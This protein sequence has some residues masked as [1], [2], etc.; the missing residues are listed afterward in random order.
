MQ[1]RPRTF[2]LSVEGSTA[3]A[4]ARGR[5]FEDAVG[6][7]SQYLATRWPDQFLLT[8][9][10]SAL[11][12][13]LR[14]GL[15]QF[16]ALTSIELLRVRPAQPHLGDIFQANTTSPVETF[17][18][19]GWKEAE[20]GIAPD[21]VLLSRR[22]GRAVLIEAKYGDTEGN[23]H[24]ERAGARATPAFLNA[25]DRVFGGK[26]RYLYVFSGPMVTVRHASE[27]QP[28]F[29]ERGR[30]A[31]EI[32]QTP[33]RRRFASARYHRQIEVLF[34]DGSAPVAW[35]TLLWD[36]DGMDALISLFEEQLGPWLQAP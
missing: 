1:R 17:T 3:I 13:D 28:K 18:E 34:G 27:V 10:T 21:R 22:S 12:A 14:R 19:S 16:F 26:A 11:P 35:N 9:D 33:E 20:E 7:F 25:V 5:D 6:E 2:G 32:V 30:R 31:G 23:A 8:K 4:N 24:I 36:S 15:K 29:G